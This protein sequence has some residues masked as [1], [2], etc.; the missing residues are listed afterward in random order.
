MS[1]T[2]YDTPFY[3]LRPMSHLGCPLV[4]ESTRETLISLN[5]V[6]FQLLCRPSD[7][8]Q[9]QFGVLS[10]S[11]HGVEY[12]SLVAVSPTASPTSNSRATPSPSVAIPSRATLMPTDPFQTHPT[13]SLSPFF[14]PLFHNGRSCCGVP[15]HS[16]CDDP[17]HPRITVSPR[18]TVNSTVLH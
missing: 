11:S 6:R 12:R 5:F 1:S 3:P 8:L 7:T 4:A 13:L 16:H 9:F 15:S 17:C 18:A 2:R 10:I 14:C